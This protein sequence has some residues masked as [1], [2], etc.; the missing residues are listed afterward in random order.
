[1]ARPV[2][3]FSLLDALVL[4][5][6]IALGFAWVRAIEVRDSRRGFR[7][8]SGWDYVDLASTRLEKGWRTAEVYLPVAA[9]L[10]IALPVL[11]CRRPGPGLRRLSRR[12]GFVA[13]AAVC[14]ALLASAAGAAA[15][16]TRDDVF[17]RGHLSRVEDHYDF[18]FPGDLIPSVGP[19][20]CGL[21]VAVG[22]SLLILGR[23]WQPSPDWLDRSGRALGLFW[24][25][26]AA[27]N[28]IEPWE[29]FG[30]M[31]FPMLKGG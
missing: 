3:R 20:H 2:R 16:T 11:A 15:V 7:T 17:L 25:I 10:T 8:L 14:V 24:L 5:A 6:A 13:P 21:A 26:W 23:R 28:V 22:W 4:V 29:F 18:S 27:I 9:A 1:M 12:P 30:R 31:T 19:A